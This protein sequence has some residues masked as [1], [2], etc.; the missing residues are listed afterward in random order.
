MRTFDGIAWLQRID[1]GTLVH[2]NVPVK[3]RHPVA[4]YR[5]PYGQAP[6]WMNPPYDEEEGA[7]PEDRV[8]ESYSV[9]VKTV[10]CKD[11]KE[12]CTAI[13]AALK[14]NEEIINLQNEGKLRRGPM[15]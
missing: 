12:I 6:P 15:A 5:A 8:V 9:M 13:E 2:F 1:N 4:R 11:F 14:A 3:H 7:T 10:H